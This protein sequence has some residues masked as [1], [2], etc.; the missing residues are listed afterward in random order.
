MALFGRDL[1]GSRTELSFFVTPVGAIADIWRNFG[2]SGVILVALG[3]GWFIKKIDN[4]T[5]RSFRIFWVVS[6]FNIFSLCFYFIFGLFFSQGVFFQILFTYFY[7]SY[8]ARSTASLGIAR[9]HLEV[10]QTVS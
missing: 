10:F 5:Y 6:T 1:I 2:W 7:C 3:L 8:S 4:F 9:R